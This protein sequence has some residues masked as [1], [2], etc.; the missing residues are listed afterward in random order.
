MTA[1]AMQNIFPQNGQLEMKIGSKTKD[2]N[3]MAQSQDSEMLTDGAEYEDLISAVGH[4]PS[5]METEVWVLVGVSSAMVGCF[6]LVFAGYVACFARHLSCSC[7]ASATCTKQESSGEVD[8]EQDSAMSS[9]ILDLQS[10]G[11][12][13]DDEEQP[14]RPAAFS[15]VSNDTPAVLEVEPS[16]VQSYLDHSS[17]SLAVYYSS[18]L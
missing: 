6:P 11:W 2:D 16:P 4:H 1:D 7:R 3:S 5:K 14:E 9:V 12:T 18:F 8:V 13:E 15:E 10:G 17:P